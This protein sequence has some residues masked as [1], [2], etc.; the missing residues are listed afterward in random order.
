MVLYFF[1]L[2]PKV[3]VKYKVEV[4]STLGIDGTFWACHVESGFIQDKLEPLS[5]R[6]RYG[7]SVVGTGAVNCQFDGSK[8]PLNGHTCLY[9]FQLSKV[10][11]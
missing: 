10:N 3:G 1:F 8:E 7:L 6:L 2:G 9:A 5:E 4:T 11:N